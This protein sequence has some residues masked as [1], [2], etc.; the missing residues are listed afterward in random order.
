MF[1]PKNESSSRQQTIARLRQGRSGHRLEKKRP[2]YHLVAGALMAGIVVLVMIQLTSLAQHTF[3]STQT[4]NTLAKEG[5]IF[6]ALQEQRNALQQQ[7]R[8]S[9]ARRRLNT[10]HNNSEAIVIS[11][12]VTQDQAQVHP[13]LSIATNQSEPAVNDTG[14]DPPISNETGVKVRFKKGSHVLNRTAMV[15]I[16]QAKKRELRPFQLMRSVPEPPTDFLNRTKP[17]DVIGDFDFDISKLKPTNYTLRSKWHGVL[18]DA[19]RHYFEV[20]WIYRMLD[21][22]AV[23]QY[24]CLHFRLTDDQAWNV[25]LESQP[26]L[27][28]PVGIMGH[29]NVYTPGE[30]RDIVAYAK[31]KGIT[32]WPEINVPVSIVWV[33]EICLAQT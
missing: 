25:R 14:I 10:T 5:P 21:V 7:A 15:E 27:A 22:L 28:H 12:N 20:K 18:L 9:N 30:L 8:E 11:S 13:D 4:H 33:G 32:V 19:G 1:R 29:E 31:T 16:Q 6:R 24:N 3:D 2:R 26:D 17:V 23:M